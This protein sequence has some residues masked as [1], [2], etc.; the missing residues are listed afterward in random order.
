M[1]S[2]NARFH[3]ALSSAGLLPLI[4]RLN[5]FSGNDLAAAL[6]PLIYEPCTT[7]T[8][9]ING[10]SGTY[11]LSNGMQQTSGAGSITTNQ[12]ISH[13]NLSDVASAPSTGSNLHMSV[14][15]LDPPPT[16]CRPIGVAR[17]DVM[18]RHY[19]LIDDISDHHGWTWGRLIR[20][21]PAMSSGLY[22]ASSDTTKTANSTSVPAV[23]FSCA[24]STSCSVLDRG[25]GDGS[26]PADWPVSIFGSSYTEDGSSGSVGTTC[27]GTA[28][29]KTCCFCNMR[30]GGY[31]IGYA[32][33]QAQV[34]ALNDAWVQ[35]FQDIGRVP[36][37]T[38][39]PTAPTPFPTAQPT[40]PSP[41]PSP[42]PSMDP[43]AIPLS[44]IHI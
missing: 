18:E 26:Q 36:T 40:M 38:A 34:Q 6:I 42:L 23:R 12:R 24:G 17:G 19:L 5:T 3:S 10:W 28:G 4:A 15:F 30:I 16:N 32:L 8:D 22:T 25:I 2:A 27:S 33:S 31:S 11:S 9:T 29:M 35:F 44:L 1:I 20:N 14:F 39:Q 37:P 41:L 13:V 43:S 7:S 21:F